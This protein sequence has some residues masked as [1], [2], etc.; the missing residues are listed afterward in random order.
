[1][2][3]REQ[4][5]EYNRVYRT[6]HKEKISISAKSYR[7]RHDP[8]EWSEKNR[9]SHIKVKYGLTI[10]DYNAILSAQ[11][12]VCAI[13]K[14]ADWN[15]KGPQIDHDHQTKRVRGILCAS[16]NTA[17]GFIKENP[18]IA[19]GM[20]EYLKKKCN[21]HPE[22]IID[23]GSKILYKKEL[24]GLL[25]ISEKTLDRWCL[26]RSLPFAYLGRRKI[27]NPAELKAWVITRT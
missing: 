12:G 23:Y 8:K 9:A 3:T 1:M 6:L 4:R 7:L 26:K 11:G 18:I 21:R 20:A 10:D 5:A 13:C 17:I 25:Q 27:F 14:R 24:A 16:C 22:Y 19:W 2:I 15:R